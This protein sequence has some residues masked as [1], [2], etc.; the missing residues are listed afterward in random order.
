[1]YKLLRSLFLLVGLFWSTDSLTAQQQKYRAE[2]AKVTLITL[3]EGIAIQG[4]NH[5][6]T[7]ILDA[8]TGQVLFLVPAQSFK[9]R[10]ALVQKY[11][12]YPGFSYSKK[13]PYIKF[14]GY[15][16]DYANLNLQTNQNQLVTIE[17]KLT[18]RGVTKPMKATGTLARVNKTQLAGTAQLIVPDVY[19]FRIGRQKD[20][21]FLRGTKLTIKVEADYRKE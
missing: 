8:K 16:V 7:S 14:K 11:F 19:A 10:S 4:L 13:Y 15:I 9:F 5:N 20:T 6:A 18:V 12:N 17:G 21:A 1:M 2:N 3:V